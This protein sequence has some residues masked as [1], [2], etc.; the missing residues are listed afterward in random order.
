MG[1]ERPG[2]HGR[3][4]NTKTTSSEELSE[5]SGRIILYVNIYL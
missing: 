4:R 1:L 3:I 5:W 2:N